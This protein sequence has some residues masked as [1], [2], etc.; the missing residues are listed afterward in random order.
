[1]FRTVY[2]VEP[3]AGQKLLENTLQSSVIDNALS[4]S[5]IFRK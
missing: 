1:M 3:G 4:V 2:S 5:L